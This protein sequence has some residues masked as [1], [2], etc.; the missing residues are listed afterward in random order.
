MMTMTMMMMTVMMVEHFQFKMLRKNAAQIAMHHWNDEL[1]NQ[2]KWA[3][4]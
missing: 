3:P 1:E 4:I 2:A